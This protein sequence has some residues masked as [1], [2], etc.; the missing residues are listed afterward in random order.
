MEAMF[1]FSAITV[2]YIIPTAGLFFL[3]HGHK[4]NKTTVCLRNRVNHEYLLDRENRQILVY[5]L[6]KCFS[7]NLLCFIRSFDQWLSLFLNSGEIC[8]SF[9]GTQTAVLKTP[10]FSIFMWCEYL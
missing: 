9:V 10:L 1:L 3:V 6:W 7:V 4:E 8:L 5:L 2:L